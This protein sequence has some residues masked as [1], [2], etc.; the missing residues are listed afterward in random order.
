MVEEHLELIE[1]AWGA[2]AKAEA[3]HG[4]RWT[5]QAWNAI[6]LLRH[7]VISARPVEPPRGRAPG[8]GFARPQRSAAVG[9]DSHWS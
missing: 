7:D 9:A 6:T 5:L 8:G 4:S 2:A 3:E 1:S